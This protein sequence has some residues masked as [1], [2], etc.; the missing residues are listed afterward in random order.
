MR[1]IKSYRKQHGRYYTYRYWVPTRILQCILYLKR[2]ETVSTSGVAICIY[3]VLDVLVLLCFI[4]AANYYTNDYFTR[5]EIVVT[6]ILVFN[7]R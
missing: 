3:I 2:N 5:I 6:H 7:K 1:I 4:H